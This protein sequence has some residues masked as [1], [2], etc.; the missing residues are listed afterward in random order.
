MES[1]TVFSL[2]GK[3]FA[4]S[5]WNASAADPVLALHG[6]LDNSGSFD[7]LAPLLPE[8]H[9]VA[10]DLAGHGLTDHRSPDAAYNIWQDVGEM[11]QLVAALGWERFTL[12]GHSRGAVIAS[13][14]AGTFP[15]QVTRL[16]LLDGFLPE[17]VLAA[18]APQQLAQS[19]ADKL[20]YQNQTPK[21]YGSYEEALQAR[22]QG[23]VKLS[24]KAAEAIAKRGM[25]RDEAGQYY[26]R[27][28]Y[29]LRGA[30]EFKLT[31]EH[32]D[33]FARRIACPTLLLLG[34]N[35]VSDYHRHLLSLN[36]RFS[37]KLFAAGHHLHMEEDAVNAVA[38][39]I[40]RFLAG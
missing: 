39:E 7:F 32:S 13:L 31:L 11:S 29:R 40:R 4:C 2:Q 37:V 24:R 12:I 35:S 18:D 8:H 16:V 30:S 15:Q 34:G 10:P 9:V 6:W 26:W 20:R 36:D 3:T 5:V 17:P 19:I 28:D 23:M 25:T 38:E 1:E 22:L 14:F 21:R 33:S 27:S